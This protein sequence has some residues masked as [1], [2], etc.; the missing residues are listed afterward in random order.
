MPTFSL[1]EAGT[2]KTFRFWR[3][4]MPSAPRM[5]VQDISHPGV[6]F[7]AVRQIAQRS[8][9]QQR[10]TVVDNAT[11]AT[12]RTTYLS[13]RAMITTGPH[14]LIWNDYD[15]D[16]EGYRLIVTDVQ[17]VSLRPMGVIC[18]ALSPNNTWDLVANWS[19]ILT[20]YAGP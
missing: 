20:P 7:E 13:Y 14:K 9:T 6:D 15:F 11:Q 5:T 19:F 4:D 17:L 10:A 2:L 12:A 8:G 18:G 1:G 16:T 3:G